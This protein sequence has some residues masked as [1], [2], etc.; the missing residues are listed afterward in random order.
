MFLPMFVCSC[1]I[2][3]NAVEYAPE[4]NIESGRIRGLLANLTTGH[5]VRKYLG[6]PFAQADRFKPPTDSAR[7]WSDV[8]D[9]ITFGKECPQLLS[10]YSD[11][12]ISEDC[13]NLNV[14]VPHT[15]NGAP[16]PVMVWIHGGAYIYGS[17][18]IYDGS[19]ISSLGKV[20]VVAINYRLTVFGFL[21]TGKDADLKGN[22]GM[23]DQIQALKWVK[24]NIE[25]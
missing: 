11:N 8:E 21:T 13:L 23:L 4:V 3:V 5:V 17:S 19:Y 24:R 2:L 12:D 18:R 22:Y 25:R 6:I 9:M 1:L 16:I 14:F 20:I 10:T 15:S 7:K